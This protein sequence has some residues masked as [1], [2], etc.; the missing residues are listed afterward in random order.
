MFGN[1]FISAYIPYLQKRLSMITAENEQVE[2]SRIVK[3][4]YILILLFAVVAIISIIFAW[5]ILNY[6]VESK[7]K[8]SFTFVPYLIT[9]LWIYNVYNLSIQLIYKQKKT[10][11]MGIITFTGALI[12]M[13]F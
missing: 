1:A 8:N 11:I 10:L 3:L 7:Y 2:K 4:N 9:G 5:I 12:Q 13:L 6:L